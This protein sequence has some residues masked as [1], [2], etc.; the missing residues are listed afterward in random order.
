[1]TIKIKQITKGD[2]IDY[3]HDYRIVFPDWA[4]TH[5]VVLVRSHELVEQ[6]IAFESLRAGSYRPSCSLT[7][8]SIP[9][10]QLIFNFLDIRNREVFPR[11]HSSKWPHIVS[12]MEAQFLPS[13]R[14]P[15]DIIEILRIAESEVLRNKITNVNRLSG[16]AAL[17]A[18]V[19]N[20][21]K[22]L[23]WCDKIE[24][25]V[26][27]SIQK[28]LDWELQHVDFSR[29]LRTSIGLDQHKWLLQTMLQQLE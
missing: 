2:L 26:K 13:I 17:N 6:K 28:P 15:L 23:Y 4:V 20:T 24:G 25:Q 8:L 14:A 22:A 9:R 18:Y 11:E 7:V 19:G 16:L 21:P 1:M 10:S 27:E 12:A 29:Q 5:D 3:F